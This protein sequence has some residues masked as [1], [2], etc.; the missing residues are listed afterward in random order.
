MTLPSIAGFLTGYCIFFCSTSNTGPM[1]SGLSWTFRED[2]KAGFR[3]A[4][5]EEV[6][7]IQDKLVLDF[8]II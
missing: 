3:S 2:N 1:G 8:E 5:R 7:R 6:A 4:R